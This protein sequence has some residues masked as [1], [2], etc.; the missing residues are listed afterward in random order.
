MEISTTIK[1]KLTF[2]VEAFWSEEGG[3]GSDSFGGTC[4]TLEEALFNLHLAKA[5]AKKKYEEA[6][7]RGDKYASV[8]EWFITADYK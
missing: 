8:T 6:K 4:N 3:M 1:V 7:K 5:D 2:K